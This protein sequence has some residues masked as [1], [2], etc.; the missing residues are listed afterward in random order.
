MWARALTVEQ[1]LH[2]LLLLAEAELDLWVAEQAG[3]V[4]LAELE[5]QVEVAL[6]LV[7]G[8]GLGRADLEQADDVVVAQHLQDL[9]LAQGCDRELGEGGEGGEEEISFER[10]ILLP[11]FSTAYRQCP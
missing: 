9:D 6:V 11:T 5:D 2:D 10:L 4:V 3:Q 7:G 1:L 8:A